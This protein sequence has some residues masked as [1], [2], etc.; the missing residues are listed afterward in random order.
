MHCKQFEIES[1]GQSHPSLL[2][3]QYNKACLLE[4]LGNYTEALKNIEWSSGIIYVHLVPG[5]PDSPEVQVN[6]TALA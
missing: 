5:D 1:L 6:L 2:I 3:T 4:E